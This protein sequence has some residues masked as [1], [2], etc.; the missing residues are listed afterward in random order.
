MYNQPGI[1]IAPD[2]LGR[3]PRTLVG[4]SLEMLRE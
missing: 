3:F 1:S 2:S 4:E